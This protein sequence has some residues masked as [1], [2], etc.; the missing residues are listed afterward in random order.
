MMEVGRAFSF[1]TDLRKCQLDTP[2]FRLRLSLG[3]GQ[4]SPLRARAVRIGLLEFDVLAFKS[5]SHS[6]P[7][8]RIGLFERTGIQ[9]FTKIRQWMRRVLRLLEQPAISV[10]SSN[11]DTVAV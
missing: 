6:P 8:Y 11:G 2:S 10:Q 7:A 3:R 9:V 5:T 4:G 1:R